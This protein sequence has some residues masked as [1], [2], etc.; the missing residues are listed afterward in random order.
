MR[1]I[2]LA[3][4]AGLILLILVALLY[5]SVHPK[6]PELQKVEAPRRFKYE[7]DGDN[8]QVWLLTDKT[9]GEQWVVVNGRCIF[10]LSV[11]EKNNREKVLDSIGKTTITFPPDTHL[12]NEVELGLSASAPSTPS[13]G[14]VLYRNAG[15][16]RMLNA[17]GED[18][19]FDLV[20]RK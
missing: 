2:L 7:Q 8:Q 13:S 11:M 1:N 10:E 15:G 3:V 9:T 6:S 5:L 16:V 12:G 17:K 19:A 18:K 14:A 20:E 4:L